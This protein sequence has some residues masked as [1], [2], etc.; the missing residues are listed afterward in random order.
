M[1]T[2]VEMA[3]KSKGSKTDNKAAEQRRIRAKHR[4]DSRVRRHTGTGV[5]FRF[6]PEL[7]ITEK[8]QKIASDDTNSVDSYP[9]YW[10]EDATQE[11]IEKLDWKTKIKLAKKLKGN[12]K[13]PWDQLSK[14]VM[15]TFQA[16]PMDIFDPLDAIE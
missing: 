6:K 5:I 1:H 14:R 13:E 2:G 11:I 4:R 15:L 9:S 7:T 10:A 8:L 3:S 16:Y 12:L